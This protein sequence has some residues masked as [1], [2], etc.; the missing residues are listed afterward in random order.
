MECIIVLKIH[1]FCVLVLNKIQFGPKTKGKFFITIIIN[2]F[3][4]K[5]KSNYIAIEYNTCYT[6]PSRLEYQPTFILIMNQT[7]NLFGTKKKKNSKKYGPS[8]T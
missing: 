2:L 7:E 4:L 1:F 8:C 5:E 3:N 6:L